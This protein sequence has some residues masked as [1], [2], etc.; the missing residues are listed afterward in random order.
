MLAV[1]SIGLC[2]TALPLIMALPAVAKAQEATPAPAPTAQPATEQLID[3][4]ADEVVYDNEADVLTATG[5]VRMSRDGNYLAA[6]R[7]SWDRKS[8]QVVAEGNVVVMTPEGD[9][10]IGERVN[11]TES[12]RDG[13]VENLLIV[14]ES[15]ARIAATRGSRSGTRT[16]LSNAV[17]SPCPVVTAE[18][19]PKD[20]SWKITAARVT[21]DSATGRDRK[22]VV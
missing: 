13:T 18:G 17:Y 19:C 9:K 3:F 11:L 10:L 14:M 20:P 5:R 22:S 15:G 21:Q 16:E 7:V 2:C 8:G 12:L 6:E 4:S 1:R